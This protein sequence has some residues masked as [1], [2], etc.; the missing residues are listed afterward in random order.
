MTLFCVQCGSEKP[1]Q[2]GL[3]QRCRARRLA[4]ANRKY[5]FT[6]ELRG[7]LRDAYA[8]GY[9]HLT[10]GLDRLVRR[11]GW[12]R[13]VFIREAHNLGVGTVGSRR[14]WAPEEDAYLA[15]HAGVQPVDAIAKALG[16]SRNSVWRRVQRRLRTSMRVS[17]GYTA[18][19]LAAVMGISWK[20]IRTSFERGFFGRVKDVQGCRVSE[21]AVVKFLVEHPDK[22]D[23][24]RVDQAW[25]KAVLFGGGS[26]GCDYVRTVQG[27]QTCQD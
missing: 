20:G 6:D 14:D 17:E 19:D 3:C 2:D 23:L 25:F 15:E 9:Q 24:R 13:F 10:A 1:G 8:G 5:V 26:R 12:P 22:Y 27:G 4:Q 21:K 16:R 7:E 18:Q 11:T